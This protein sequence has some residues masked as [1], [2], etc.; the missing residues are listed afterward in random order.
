LSAKPFGCSQGVV[1]AKAFH[2]VGTTA[3]LFAPTPLLALLIVMQGQ[4]AM[5]LQAHIT[6]F[7]G[8]WWC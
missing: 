6:E 3:T 1:A 4:Q 5:M 8:N 2:K 7:P